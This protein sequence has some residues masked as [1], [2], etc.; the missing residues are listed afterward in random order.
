MWFKTP[1]FTSIAAGSAQIQAQFDS[2]VPLR[3]AQNTRKCTVDP[4]AYA[5]CVRGRLARVHALQTP[6]T[7]QCVSLLTI[8]AERTLITSCVGIWSRQDS[9]KEPL[10]FSRASVVGH[11]F[12]SSNGWTGVLNIR[13]QGSTDIIMCC[14]RNSSGKYVPIMKSSNKQQYI[15][16]RVRNALCERK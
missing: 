10:K 6:V 14:K 5:F 12:T 4:N 9:A 8:Q 2:V 13:S 1:N 7:C 11:K 16:G 15:R 3:F